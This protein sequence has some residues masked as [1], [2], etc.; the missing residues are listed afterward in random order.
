MGGD[1]RV[2]A[3][4]V[5]DKHSTGSYTIYQFLFLFSGNSSALTRVAYEF[6][7]DSAKH[8]IKYT[9]VRYCPHLFSNSVDNPENAKVK[10][11][12]T[13]RDAVVAIN[14]GLARGMKD[15][16]I[17]VYTILCCMTHRPGKTRITCICLFLL[18]EFEF[19]AT[20]V[21]A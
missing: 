8:N 13:P 3:G 16:G 19:A 4:K 6:C 18:D 20:Y 11:E 1:K 15:F 14:E 17:K 5:G 10:G 12:F 7:E 2:D 9:E 21:K